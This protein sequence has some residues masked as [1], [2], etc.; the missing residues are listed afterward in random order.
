MNAATKPFTYATRDEVD[1][2]LQVLAGQIPNDLYGHVFF[3]SPCGSVNSGGLPYP[4]YYPDD[5]KINPE[6]GTNIFNGDAMLFRFDLNEKGK[7]RLKTAML[8]TPCYYADEATKRGTAYAHTKMRFVS[9]GIARI[10]HGLGAR[11]QLN[12]AISPFKL[13]GDQYSRLTA[14]FDMGRPWEVDVKTM[15][16]KTPIGTYAKWVSAFPKVYNAPFQ[17][18]QTTAH[19]A[20][21]PLT[22]EFF[23]VNFTKTFATMFFYEKFNQRLGRYRPRIHEVLKKRVKAHLHLPR[24]QQIEKVNDVYKQVDYHLMKHKNGSLLERIRF[25]FLWLLSFFGNI[26]MRIGDVIYG[27]KSGT[28]VVRWKDGVVKTWKVLDTKT[29]KPIVINQCMHQNNIS[30]DYL[31]LSDSAFKFAGDIMLTNPFPHDLELDKLLRD[32]LA[33]PQ[34]PETPIFII[35][36]ADLDD[37]TDTVKAHRMVI[38]LEVVHFSPNYANPNGQITLHTANNAASC[39]A[40][41]IRPYDELVIDQGVEVFENTIGL[42]ATGEMDVG[43]IGKYVVDGESGKLL[44]KKVIHLT[45]EEGEKGKISA[46]TWGIG[47]HTYRDIISSTTIV[48]EV[49]QI[50]WQSYGTDPRFLTKFL[51][52]LYTDYPHRIIP[53]DELVEQNRARIP[54]CL[55]RQNTDTM[56][57]ED[58]YVFEYNENFRSLQFVPRDRREQSTAGID[59]A[60]DGYIFCTLV[61]GSTDVSKDEYTREVWIFDAADL[62]NGPVCKLSHPDMNY[63]FTIH[64][65]WMADCESQHSTYRVD[66]QKDL[67]YSINRYA[68]RRGKFYEEFMEE[69]VYSHFRQDG[70]Q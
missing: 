26:F 41:W 1:C 40:E 6:Y 68:S 58:Y 29:G 23:S 67:E 46:H 18:V 44:D 49:K 51:E 53:I 11:N 43:R 27:N 38:D 47:L 60:V 56:E 69:H 13:P 10:S 63:A 25:F 39:A 62:K 32:M 37:S 54:F 33:Y 36:R 64:S 12:T 61:N 8:K 14:N 17:F 24:E 2:E 70:D 57:A 42:M 4:K 7:V 45:G 16:L 31:I 15:K 21:D 65:T 35:K 34:M 66:I 28:S 9:F 19:P 3:N 48:E 50:Y 22:H 55:L 5:P 52:S 30:K 59:L 20:F